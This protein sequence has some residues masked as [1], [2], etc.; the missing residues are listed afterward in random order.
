[1]YTPGRHILSEFHESD[2]DIFGDPQR[3]KNLM[4]KAACVSGA[5][6]LR[7][8]FQRFD[9]HGVSGV[10]VIAESH[11]AVHTWPEYG[12]AAVDLVTR[13]ERIDPW[14]AHRL[15]KNGLAAQSV[16]SKELRRGKIVEYEHINKD[17]E[18]LRRTSGRCL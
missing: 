15:L 5:S 11:I 12:Y 17:D 4:N 9:P 14:K 10:V 1:M 3:I 13:S 16:S 18:K 8:V 6:I 2:R 7:S